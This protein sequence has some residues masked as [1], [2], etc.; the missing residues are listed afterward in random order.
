[1]L[2]LVSEVVLEPP[3]RS[4]SCSPPARS[5]SCSPL[6]VV[7]NSFPVEISLSSTRALGENIGSAGEGPS[8]ANLLRRDWEVS[9]LLD[10]NVGPALSADQSPAAGL[11]V[12]S[13]EVLQASPLSREWEDYFSSVPAAHLGVLA[14]ELTELMCLS[15]L[16][17]AF[18]APWEVDAP[19]SP[20]CRDRDWFLRLLGCCSRPWWSRHLLLLMGFLVAS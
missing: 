4:P 17:E 9:S 5:P 1:M 15:V 20:L 10:A 2:P 8:L 3:A 13:T 16:K 11:A 19:A 6:E 14:L 12:T 7:L 18:S